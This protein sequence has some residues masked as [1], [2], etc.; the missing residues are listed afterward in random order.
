MARPCRPSASHAASGRGAARRQKPSG[1]LSRPGPYPLEGTRPRR[2]DRRARGAGSGGG[3]PLSPPRQAAQ[4]RAVV[5]RSNR[6]R[7]A[8]YPGQG[9]TPSTG[10]ACGGQIAVPGGG[11]AMRGGPAGLDSARGE[12][13]P[14]AGVVSCGLKL[15]FVTAASNDCGVSIVADAARRPNARCD[16]QCRY[17]V[18]AIQTVSDIQVSGITG[19]QVVESAA[20]GSWAL[21]RLKNI[22]ALKGDVWWYIRATGRS[23]VVATGLAALS[24]PQIR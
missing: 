23:S 6:R 12:Q 18:I 20:R 24:C 4:R 10:H 9:R 14:S 8:V 15:S 1:S 2:P 7:P 16:Q 21:E 5:R 13:L 3:A 11:P 19:A 17:G 22:R